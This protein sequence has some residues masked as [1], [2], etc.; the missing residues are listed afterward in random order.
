VVDCFCYEMK[1]KKTLDLGNK[2]QVIKMMDVMGCVTSQ[3]HA[4]FKV[5]QSQKLQLNFLRSGGIA[6]FMKQVTRCV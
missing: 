4:D 5:G 3:G 1:K 6:D 2:C